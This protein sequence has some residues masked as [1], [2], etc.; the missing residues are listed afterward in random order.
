MGSQV[1]L[2]FAIDNPERTLALVLIGGYATMRDNPAVRE[3]WT[4]TVSTLG[5]PVDPA[6]VTAFQHSTLAQPVPP[7]W[8]DMVVAESLKVP[9][10]VWREACEAFLEDD[11]SGDLGRIAAETLILWGDRDA[12]CP[13]GDQD[14]LAAGIARSRLRIY[15]D[16]GHGLHWEEPR[17]VA[18]DIAA[19]VQGR[20]RAV[21]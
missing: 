11:A 10:R 4:S 1:A 5:D 20:F 2:R 13:R 14:A 6:F 9:A 3:L 7:D 16:A 18:A 8:L 17:R 15:R 21:A 12:I 19:F